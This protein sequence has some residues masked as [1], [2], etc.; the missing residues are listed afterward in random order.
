VEIQDNN[1]PTNNGVVDASETYGALIGAIA[2][3]GGPAYDFRDIAPV[4]NQDGG[5]PGGNIR[6]GFI[7][8]PD[9][10]TFVDR[11]GGTATSATIPVIGATGVELTF[12]PGRIDP[13]N[14]AWLDS[15]KPL[16]GEFLFDGEKVFVAVN[17]FNSKGGDNPLF[18]RIQ[19]PVLISEI[20]RLQQAAVVNDF[21][22]SV[23]NLDPAAN[24]MVIGDLNDFQ[25]SAPLAVLRD[26]DLTNLVDT[27]PAAEQYTYIFDGN[28]QVL[29]SFLV[30]ANLL[31]FAWSFDIVHANADYDADERPTDH[32]PLAGQFCL[33]TTAPTLTASASPN[34]LWPPNHKYR[35]VEATYVVSDD[36]DPNPAVILVSVTSDEPDSGT[37]DEDLP[38]DIIILDDTHFRLRAE[39]AEWGDGR[40]YTITYQATDACGNSTLATA[41]VSVPHDV[42]F[43]TAAVAPAAP[44]APTR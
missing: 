16:V 10:V 8:R 42:S 34:V 39:R 4:N 40:V 21:V 22:E 23:L 12:S 44:A 29:D 18:G 38:N 25:F 20:Q 9:R 43:E 2:T 28:S 41:T 24:V 7:F 37:G 32:E 5:E 30:T 33:D 27:L 17:H 31:D 1:G 3:A 26:D 36:A 19:P 35:Q 14:V 13:N 11:P 6:V 15:R